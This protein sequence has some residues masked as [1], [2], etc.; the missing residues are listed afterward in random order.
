MLSS[1]SL[2]EI[3]QQKMAN[4]VLVLLAL[5]LPMLKSIKRLVKILIACDV[6]EQ[7][8][9]FGL[10]ECQKLEIWKSSIPKTD[11]YLNSTFH[12]SH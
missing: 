4:K 10:E 12:K 1:L 8:G 9:F 11:I 6:S 2:C 3:P 5:L 7:I